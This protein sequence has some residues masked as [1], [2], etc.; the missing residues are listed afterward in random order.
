MSETD[1][2]FGKIIAKA[3]NNPAFKA[4][5]IANPAATLKAEGIDVPVGMAV[6]V[7]EN[8]DRIF[9]LLLP[10]VPTNELSDEAIDVVAGGI[11]TPA[12]PFC[13]LEPFHAGCPYPQWRM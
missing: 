1:T 8:T 13:L 3:W 12:D 11:A 5:L 2:V 10:P 9:H 6:T 7:V 4:E